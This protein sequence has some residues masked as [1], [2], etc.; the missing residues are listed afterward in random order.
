VV[1][2]LS[3]SIASPARGFFSLSSDAPPGD[4][5]VTDRPDQTESGWKT[6]IEYAVDRVCPWVFERMEPLIF[7]QEEGHG[8]AAGC[9]FHLDVVR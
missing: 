5:L 8:D 1:V 2:K 7:G 9:G 6:L 4:H 3:W